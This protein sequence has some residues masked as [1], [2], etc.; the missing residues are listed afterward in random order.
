MDE[1][2]FEILSALNKTRNITKAAESQYLSQSSFSKRIAA[3][4]D[5]LGIT[6]ILRS[7]Q[8]VHFTPEGEEVLERTM[9]AAKQLELM[10]ENIAARK[11]YVCGTLNAG[12]SIN[13]SLFR[14]PDILTS[15]RHQ[16]PHVNTQI[17]TDHSK[18]LFL[19]I[20]EGNI[21]VA[22][23]RGEYPWKGNKILLERENLCLICSEKDKDKPL[24]D[25][26]Y[27][28][29]K[30]DATFEREL[31]QWLRENNIRT[32]KNGIYVDNIITCVKIV[33]KGLG[34]AI[35]P[36]ICLDDFTGHV[37]PLTFN[38]GEPFVRST[39]LMYSENALSLPQVSAFIDVVKNHNK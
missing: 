12:I 9:E 27:I 2:D 38:N 22:I 15:Y 6:L 31:G 35:V 20:L 4:E 13:Y 14:L 19:E 32:E 29:R 23:I 33:S 37:R 28:G 30:T 26:P 11:D 21:D 17:V 25:I 24:N 16:Y 7:R 5:D 10:R 8:G 39:Y 3:I 18:K 34:W 36:E 1:R